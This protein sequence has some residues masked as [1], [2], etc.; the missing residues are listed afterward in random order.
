MFCDAGERLSEGTPGPG[1]VAGVTLQR[2][3]SLVWVRG[4]ELEGPDGERRQRLVSGQAVKEFLPD[5][6]ALHVVVG[7]CSSVFR[8]RVEHAADVRDRFRGLGPVKV[9][10]TLRTPNDE[11]ALSNLRD[12]KSVG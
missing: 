6:E 3:D 4:A 2:R 11:R 1:Q 5:I 10:E 12:P 7:Q 8:V 9:T